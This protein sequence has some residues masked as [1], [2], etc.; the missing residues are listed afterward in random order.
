MLGGLPERDP[1]D[2]VSMEA[3]QVTNGKSWAEREQELSADKDDM[4]ED[5]EEDGN[6]DESVE[7]H[8]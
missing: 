1:M 6:D 5:E 2:F 3:E 4:D 7:V 8:T